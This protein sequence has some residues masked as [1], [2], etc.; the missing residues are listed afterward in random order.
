MVEIRRRIDAA[1]S[2]VRARIIA[3]NDLTQ[4]RR[5][6]LTTAE[7]VPQL[8]ASRNFLVL[9]EE[10]RS[11]EN[12][13]ASRGSTTMTASCDATPCFQVLSPIWS[14]AYFILLCSDV[15][16]TRRGRRFWRYIGTLGDR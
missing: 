7:M 8:Q 16:R 14:R 1:A 6:V 11:T 12:R 5:T 15:R 10:L 9:Q 2:N 13:I 4:S 3:E